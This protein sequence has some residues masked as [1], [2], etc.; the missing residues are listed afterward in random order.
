MYL[1]ADNDAKFGDSFVDISKTEKRLIR[2]TTKTYENSGTYIFLKLFKP[3]TQEGE[4]TV[5]QRISLTLS[6]LELLTEKL[7][8]IRQQRKTSKTLK[9]LDRE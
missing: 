7:N 9:K 2:A 1:T 8:E 6:E 4:F 5:Y 3:S